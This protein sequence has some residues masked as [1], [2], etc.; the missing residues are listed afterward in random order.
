MYTLSKEVN[1]KQSLMLALVVLSAVGLISLFI[2]G[3]ETVY[4]L[5]AAIGFAWLSFLA[6]RQRR[7]EITNDPGYYEFRRAIDIVP[8]G[9]CGYLSALFLG[10]FIVALI[11]RVI[12]F[13]ASWANYPELSWIGSLM[14][15]LLMLIAF[16]VISYYYYSEAKFIVRA[17]KNAFERGIVIVMGAMGDQVGAGFGI[18]PIGW[19][20]IKVDVE[21]IRKTSTHF[22]TNITQDEFSVIGDTVKK[23]FKTEPVLTKYTEKEGS[24]PISVELMVL[25]QIRNLHKFYSYGRTNFETQYI[26]VVIMS[27]LRR[28]ISNMTPSQI[29]S[30]RNGIKEDFERQYAGMKSKLEQDTGVDILDIKM[31]D[32]TLPEESEKALASIFNKAQEANADRNKLEMQTEVAS[33]MKEKLGVSGEVALN[34]V[35]VEGGKTQKKITEITITGSDKIAEGLGPLG[36]LIIGWLSSKL[37][38]EKGKKKKKKKGGK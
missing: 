16:G 7:V 12:N 17:E 13:Q 30:N 29:I 31:S 37:G 6:Y 22:S 34:A 9:V 1:V 2:L 26:P 23:K 32:I 25:Y 5:I 24:V 4:S 19:P 28:K 21:D 15:P 33:V 10:F 35:Q 3:L 18:L 20:F 11:D 27:D 36:S 14:K 38:G 8:S